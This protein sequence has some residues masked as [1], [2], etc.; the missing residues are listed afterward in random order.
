MFY[1]LSKVQNRAIVIGQI[2]SVSL[3]LLKVSQPICWKNEFSVLKIGAEIQLKLSFPFHNA[4]PCT[5]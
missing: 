5:L 2:Q 4:N 3:E 1:L